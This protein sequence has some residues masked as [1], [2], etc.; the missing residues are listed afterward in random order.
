MSGQAAFSIIIPV[1]NVQNDIGNCLDSILAQSY[2]N[3]EVLCIDDGSTDR[4]RQVIQKYAKKDKRIRCFHHENK[5][6]S[7]TR[8]I[9]IHKARGMYIW[10]VDADDWVEPNALGCIADEIKK[11]KSDIL[12][13]GGEVFFSKDYDGKDSYMDQAFIYFK[14]N[15]DT[16]RTQYRNHSVAA[17]LYEPGSY[18]LIWNK[19]YKRSLIIS[20]HIQYEES[21]K[22]GEDEA[23]LF[24]IYPLAD[25]IDY[26]PNRL[27][28]YQRNRQGS[29]TELIV[30]KEK[31]RAEQNLKMAR[32]VAGY[33]EKQGLFPEYTYQ[34]LE[35]YTS[36][37]YDSAMAVK[38]DRSFYKQYV[39]RANDFFA[40]NFE[41]YQEFS[42]RA[43]DQSKVWGWREF[44]LGAKLLYWPNKARIFKDYR[45]CFGFGTAVKKMIPHW[46]CMITEQMQK[47]QFGAFL[48]HFY[49]Y[50]WKGYQEYAAL[51][52][53]WG[54]DC[55]FIS[56]TAMGTGDLYQVS[57]MLPQWLR[58]NHIRQYCMLVVG[59]SEMAL[60]EKMF[61]DL[62]EGHLQKIDM[63]T[64]ERLRR[65]RT[66][67]GK[68]EI[69]FHY[70]CHYDNISDYLQ[71]TWKIQ[72]KYGWNMLELY[73]YKG[74]NLNGPV[75]LQLPDIHREENN[76]VHIFASMQLRQGKTAL[77][78]PYAT[79]AEE[80]PEEFWV[81]I[82]GIL[83]KKGYSVCTNCGKDEQPVA[84]TKSVFVPYNQIIDFC[85]RAG[86]FIGI[87][88]GLSDIISSSSCKK[89]LIYPQYSNAWPDDV[90]VAYVGLQEMGLAQDVKEYA[91]GDAS[92]REICEYCEKDL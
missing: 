92:W 31:K 41:M 2:P 13:F 18:P 44:R 47:T 26:I 35:R 9:G 28:H 6:V 75:S 79:C 80:I 68:D 12:V 66:F 62:Y 51:K 17:L 5:G 88:S 39:K 10:F 20:N 21:L 72:G 85:D 56:C 77:L 43:L 46:K 76:S 38:S 61:S 91:V 1:Y 25:R 54:K 74:M 58:E 33:W 69:D 60:A 16:R 3:F 81:H 73:K 29:A 57:L 78:S 89:I 42:L 86:L 65:L 11:H 67:V 23:F 53:K 27:Y 70:F 87:R 40:E 24:Q 32:I 49:F 71:I 30:K 45:K 36:L 64:H 14:K 84:G 90:A 52:K 63:R 8:N 82:A 34:Y 48:Y 55:V 4:S 22:L 50:I 7:Y 83:R 59:N 19:V 37:L 15:L